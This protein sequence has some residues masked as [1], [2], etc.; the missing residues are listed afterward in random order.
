MKKVMINVEFIDAETGKRRKAGSKVQMTEARVEAI[1]AVDPNLITVYGT[2]E[3]K[4]AE[5]GQTASE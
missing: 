2:V 3:E 4:P 1:R 5:E